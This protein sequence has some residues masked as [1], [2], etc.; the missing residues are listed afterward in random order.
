MKAIR[1]AMPAIALSGALLATGCAT[2]DT[3]TMVQDLDSH[4]QNGR[5]EGVVYAVESALDLRDE[6]TG[7]LLPVAATPKSILMHLEAGESWRLMGNYRRAIAHYDAVEGL[8]ANED[9]ESVGAKI[10]ESIGAALLNDS[11][12]SYDPPPSERI[13]TNFYKALAFW[14]EGEPD[15]ARVEFNRANDRARIAVERYAKDIA[16]A[17]EEAA[18]K[19]VENS[20]EQVDSALS[21]HFPGIDQWEVYDDFVNPAVAYV[22][23]LFL[24]GGQNADI[25]KAETLMKRVRGMTG[26]HPVI[27][28]D[29]M[30]LRQTSSIGGDGHYRWVVF[31]AG[32]GPIYKEKKITMPW[33]AS[34]NGQPV[35]I[36]LALPEMTDRN[37]VVDVN[38]VV[39]N[40]KPLEFAPLA[41]MEKVLRTEYKKRMPPTVARAAVSAGAKALI[42]KEMGDRMGPMGS[43]LGMAYSAASTSADTRIWRSTPEKWAVAKISADQGQEILRIPYGNGESREIYLPAGKNSFV[44]IKQPTPASYPLVEVYEL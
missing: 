34:M 2:Y 3:S 25:E 23:A 15:N 7:K 31:E 20:N 16:K 29:L 6:E 13:L 17:Q 36:N 8:F 42:Q 11:A 12:R 18:E 22:N 19:G 9:T 33:L 26:E 30:A 24:A 10:G 28:T 44:Y 32:L 40:G 1:K 43:L 5:Y 35:M 38:S 4:Y 14:G 37:G 39:V 21:Q 41:S 27:D